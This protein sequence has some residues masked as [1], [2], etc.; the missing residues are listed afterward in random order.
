MNALMQYKLGASELEVLLALARAGN[1]A[2]ASQLL[3]IDSSTVFRTVQRV[4]KA[5]GQRLFER[6]RAGYRPTE[7]GVQLAQHAERIEVELDAARTATQNG[8]GTVGG[9][10]RISTTDTILSG[11]LLPALRRLM[12]EHPHLRLEASASNELANLTQRQA[13]I[14]IRATKR[15]PPHVVGRS[16]GPIRLALFVAKVPGR[17]KGQTIDPLSATWIAVDDALPEHPSVVWRRRHYPQVTPRVLVNSVQSV[18]EGIVAGIGIGIVPL[19]LAQARKDLVA[20]SEPLDECETQL[21]LLTHPESRH[22]RRIS[23]VAAHLA[24]AIAL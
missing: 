16:L 5:L 23:V 14:A 19:F 18:F 1:L 2:A 3:G 12:K 8:A 4:E 24:N 10:V 13:D 17:A 15:P 9:T 22:L 7:L 11:L 21:W 6:S 20:L